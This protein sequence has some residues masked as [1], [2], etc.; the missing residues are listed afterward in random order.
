[1]KS[2]KMIQRLVILAFALVLTACGSTPQPVVK[3]E[4]NVLAKPNL[5]V[6]YV[7]QMPEDTKA[8]THIWGA[9]CLLCYGVASAL[10]SKLDKHLETSISGEGLEEIAQLVLEGYKKHNVAVKEIELTEKD[11]KKLKK[12]KT[13]AK[14]GFAKKDYR[15]L[16]E[17]HGVDLLVVLN[18]WRHGAYRGFSSYVP[19]TDPQGY[20]AGQLFTLDLNTNGY[21]QYLEID[22]KIQPEGE[23]DE[24]DTFPSVTTSY[25][26]A[27]E[28]AKLKVKEAI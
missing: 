4:T 16:K 17:K 22:E 8:T 11:L 23:W 20:V 12:F 25:Y 5:T 19:T 2:I 21:I 13:K 3:L 10:T 27:L 1:M 7:V 26:Q 9:D 14:I 15:S 18:L 6:G 24:P 28:N